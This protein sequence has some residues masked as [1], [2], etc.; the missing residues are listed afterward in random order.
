MLSLFTSIKQR[1][2]L[3][4]HALQG[5]VLP[6]IKPQTTSFVLGTFA[7]LTRGKAE[8]LAENAL[9]RQQL[10]ILRRR[11]KRPVDKKTDRLLLVLLASMVRTWKQAL[12]LVQP[13]TLL[14]G[15]REFFRLFWMRKSKA[16]SSKPRL[17]LATIS[18]RKRDGGKQLAS[19]GRSA[20]VGN[21]SS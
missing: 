4:L 6:W 12:L 10:S 13:E 3:R 2:C 11:V 16:R 14:R 19:F 9:L 21:C 5:R 20:S 7:D 18:L 17:S 8:L 15:P 1:V